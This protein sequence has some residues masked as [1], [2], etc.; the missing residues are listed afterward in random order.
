[1]QASAT[2]RKAIIPIVNSMAHCIQ[3]DETPLFPFLIDDVKGVEERLDAAIGAP[4]RNREPD[5]KTDAQRSAS[6]SGKPSQFVANDIDGATR[7]DAGHRVELAGDC[8][9]IGEQPINRHQSRDAGKSARS[10]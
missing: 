8:P 2:S 10:A 1:M 5:H 7:E 6:L 9:R 3:P 4:Q